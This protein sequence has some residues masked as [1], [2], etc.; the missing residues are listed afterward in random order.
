MHNGSGGLQIKEICSVGPGSQKA[1]SSIS[2]HVFWLVCWENKELKM[3]GLTI[4][5]IGWASDNG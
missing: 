4:A 1:V 3:E 5:V 2:V